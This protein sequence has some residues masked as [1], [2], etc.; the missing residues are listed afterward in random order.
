MVFLFLFLFVTACSDKNQTTPEQTGTP[1]HRDLDQIKKD[2]KLR[3]LIAYNSTSYF[4][5][6][7]KAMGYEYELVKRLADHLHLKLELHVSKNMDSLINELNRGKADLLAYGL[8]ITTDRKKKVKFTD[9]LYLTHQVLI[10]KKPNHWR[11][12]RWAA[13]QKSLIHDPIELIGD[14]V[15]VR[16]NTSYF[17]RIQNLSKEMGGKIYID[18][19][20][21]NIST[22]KIIKMVVDGNI[23]YTVADDNLAKINASYYPILDIDVPIS[24]SQRVAWAVRPNSPQLLAAINQ[25]IKQ[26]RKETDYYVIYNKYFK[27]RRDF[28]KRVKSDFYSLNKNRI[29]KYDSIIKKNAKKIHWDWRLLASQIYQESQFKPKASSWAG[30]QGLMQLTP[31]T[32][33]ELGVEN[34]HNAAENVAAGTN[35]L[36]Q[37]EENFMDVEDS[38]QRIKFTLAAFNCGYSHVTD[39]QNLAE[40]RGLDSDRWDGN[41]EKMILALSYPENYQ[42]DAVKFGYV[43]GIEPYTYVRQI[44]DRYNHYKNFIK[45]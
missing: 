3:V 19:L 6:R 23:K 15:S 14:T 12:M 2:G 4:L 18:T 24:F 35:Y 13:I 25:W 39:A 7:G 1:F 37:L 26:E 42:D 33:E 11:K 32:A 22:D 21:G 10:Q 43:R 30:A 20:K 41:V 40:E 9:Y 17:K 38:I 27:N 16:E 31:E 36:Q 44:F 8:T 28:R 45:R 5:Y 34:I 29:S